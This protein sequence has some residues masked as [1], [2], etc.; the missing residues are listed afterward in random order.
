M[1]TKTSILVIYTGGTIGMLKDTKTGA[2]YPYDFDRLC[3]HMPEIREFDYNISSVSFDPLIDSSNINPSDWIK[4]AGIIEDNYEKYDGFVV[5]HGSD[6]MAFSASALSFMLENL[7]KP[8]IFTGSQLPMGVY[9]TDGRE[10]FTTSIEIAAAKYNNK[11]TV[12]EVCLYFEYQLY[13]GN[14][15][16]KFSAENFEAFRSINYPILAEAGVNIKFNRGAIKKHNNKGLIVHKKLNSNIAILKLFPG[17][18]KE[19]IN[20]TINIKGLQGII[21]E[22]YGSGNAPTDKWFTEAI[23]KAIKKGIIILNVTQCRG[24]S[25][26]IGKYETSIELG[27][28][29]V[30]S[31]YDM[32][33]ESA[34]GKL[35]YLLAKD[36]T[37]RKTVKLLQTPLRGEMTV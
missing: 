27:R 29:G 36:F 28:I 19:I 24:G 21:L 17:I 8:V 5:L 23:E 33:T 25:V 3:N 22:T 11:P 26:E 31:G 30:I 2:L 7:N 1:K 4:L 6:T 34:I 18:S 37:Y 16:H 13:R 32:I 35:M 9:R 14:R 10:N 15:A 12:P 20:A